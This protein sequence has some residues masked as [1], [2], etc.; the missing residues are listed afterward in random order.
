[1]KV[2]LISI[3]KFFLR[4]IYAVIKPFC[5]TKNQ[6]LYLSRQSNEKS[7]DM[8]LLEEELKK[9]VPN[10]NQVF[11]LK[12]MDDGFSQKV[13]Y[14]FHILGDMRAI[15]SSKLLILD[16]YSIPVSCLRHKEDLKVVQMWHAIGAIKQ[17]GLQSLGSKEGRDEKVSAAMCMHENYD[18][19]L[20]PSK[21]AAKFY[22]E[23]F[24]CGA[25]KI[26]I[27]S[28][29]RVD[30]ILNAKDGVNK[31]FYLQNPGL[32]DTK[33]VLYLPTFRDREA[34][35]AQELKVA[36]ED[37][38]DCKLII[39]AHPLSRIRETQEYTCKGDFNTYDLMKIADVIITDYSACAFEGALLM[40]P[41][42]FFVPDYELY[43]EE[44]GL[45]V[46]LKAEL[47]HLVFEDAEE[48]SKTISN[49]TYNYDALFAFKSKY[50][51]NAKDNNTQI[52][53]KYLSMLL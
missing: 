37:Y 50:V 49:K 38:P 51:E 39:K 2:L 47:P 35:V 3:F 29:P 4:L 48:L 21:A 45:N 28:L 14:F 11:R 52:L 17:F 13:K 26:K 7:I 5:K 19:V 44:R 15:S 41:L 22:M 27:C 32:A 20:A 1:M 30:Y 10:T 16:T 8:L 25:K 46:D 12:M 9:T 42:Y 31:E 6:I 36:M 18:F 34:Y 33:I 23:A 24:G 43:K 53:A 40:K